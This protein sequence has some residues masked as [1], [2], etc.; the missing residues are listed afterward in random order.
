MYNMFVSSYMAD[1]IPFHFSDSRVVFGAAHAYVYVVL[2][3]K[4]TSLELIREVAGPRCW[5]NYVAC[6]VSEMLGAGQWFLFQN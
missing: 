5:Y 6:R 4:L 1:W 3:F 2:L